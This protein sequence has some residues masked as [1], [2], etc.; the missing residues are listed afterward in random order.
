MDVYKAGIPVS[1]YNFGQPR[2]GDAAYAAFATARVPTFR[3]VVS[4]ISIFIYNII[5]I[6]LF[7]F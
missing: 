3:V 5:I 6:N 7:L 1:V 2:T 4:S